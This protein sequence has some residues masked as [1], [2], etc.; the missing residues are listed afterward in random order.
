MQEIIWN[1]SCLG[2]GGAFSSS[3]LIISLLY[4]SGGVGFE[5]VR[6]FYAYIPFLHYSSIPYVIIIV[7][8]FLVQFF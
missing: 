2:V 6:I 8:D 3:L 1:I 7:S 4:N 5:M